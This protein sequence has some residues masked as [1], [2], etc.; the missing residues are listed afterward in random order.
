MLS[1]FFFVR[2][3]FGFVR[4][5]RQRLLN[6]PK[7]DVAKRLNE[8]GKDGKPEGYKPQS[9]TLCNVRWNTTYE[10]VLSA[11]LSRARFR[12]AAF[13]TG[14]TISNWYLRRLGFLSKMN[15]YAELKTPYLSVLRG[16]Y[17]TEN[18]RGETKLYSKYHFWN[19]N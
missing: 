3:L 8:G 10:F 4:V 9:A 17:P 2:I 19:K 1:F 16:H 13:Y 15:W 18:E 12:S 11:I 7:R 14:W 5:R 6:R